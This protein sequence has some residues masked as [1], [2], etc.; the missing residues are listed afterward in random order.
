[1]EIRLTPLSGAATIGGSAYLVSAGS[2][3]LLLDA[4]IGG[5]GRPPGT[6]DVGD[7]DACWL[8]HAHLDHVGAL[9]ELLAR[10]PMMDVYAT[11]G[12]ARLAR[13]ALSTRPNLDSGRGE[14]AAGAINTVGYRQWI[15][16]SSGAGPP[17]RLMA[18]RA[19][20]IPGA[21]LCVVEFQMPGDHPYR[22]AYTGD[23]CCHDL[24]ATPAAELPV[25][26]ASFQIDTLVMEG[27]LAT[28]READAVDV[29]ESLGRLWSLASSDHRGCLIPA[30]SLAESVE[31]A[32][33]LKQA[34]IPFS[35][36]RFSAS[37]VQTAGQHVQ[38]F[39]PDSVRYVG[40]RE[41]RAMLESGGCVVAPGDQMEAG[42][43]AGRLATQVVGRDEAMVIL[44]NRA[45]GQTPAGRLLASSPG[46]S[47]KIGGEEVERRCRVEHLA[48]PTHAPRWQLLETVSLLS[49]DHVVLI[50]GRESQLW[51]LRRALEK[52]G[53]TGDITVAEN[54]VEVLLNGDA[55]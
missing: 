41:A 33:G 43:P 9:P 21:A 38:G 55:P 35:V 37:V 42:S 23:F 30:Q 54:T 14:G 13:T 12:T 39:D 36:H 11:A 24:P 18:F 47:L 7:V 46:D 15:D 49:P 20:H 29:S 50:H 44:L 32:V 34:D 52:D 31:M 25:P 40:T 5:R 45:H 22:V 51:A 16:L 17:A 1:M 4:G 8:S 28:D 10:Q 53:F 27:I 26:D 19:G 3:R 2:T 6:W 48:V